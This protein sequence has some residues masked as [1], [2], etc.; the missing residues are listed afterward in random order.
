MVLV[1]AVRGGPALGLVTGV[2]VQDPVAAAAAEGHQPAAVDDD[3]GAVGVHHLGR[4]VEGDRDRTRVRSRSRCGPRRPPPPARRPR[5]SWPGSRYRRPDR[6]P[7]GRM[8]HGRRRRP[9][10]G[11]RPGRWR[12][13]CRAR[14][15]TPWSSV[16]RRWW[17]R[18]SRPVPAAAG[19][20]GS[21]DDS[22]RQHR[23][24]RRRRRRRRSTVTVVDVE[25]TAAETATA[26]DW[27][28]G[29]D[30]VAGRRADQEQSSTRAGAGPRRPVDRTGRGSSR[31]TVHGSCPRP[32]RGQSSQQRGPRSQID[33]P[34]VRPIRPAPGRVWHGG[35]PT[36]TR[37]EG[38][39][40]IRHARRP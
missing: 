1:L 5:C 38:T 39:R 4:G 17:S 21:P 34:D 30:S 10:A 2:L 29:T 8:G 18:R 33:Q 40:E 31:R 37:P 27:T 16:R 26:P 6:L 36:G 15:S 7:G 19:S 25:T 35:D 24:R 22:I 11:G 12:R 3:L 13:R 14:G 20:P 9:V 32:Q 23:P 28:V